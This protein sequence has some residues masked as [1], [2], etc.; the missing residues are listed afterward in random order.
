MNSVSFK[1]G[2]IAVLAVD[3]ILSTKYLL[4]VSFYHFSDSSSGS[5]PYF[6]RE[7]FSSNFC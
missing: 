3:N 5:N 6:S 4:C 2:V 1:N 7:I